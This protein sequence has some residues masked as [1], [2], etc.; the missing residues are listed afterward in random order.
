M[1]DDRMDYMHGQIASLG[2]FV[3]MYI[4]TTHDDANLA[5]QDI[6]HITREARKQIQA[7]A[8]DGARPPIIDGAR[9]SLESVSEITKEF[10]EQR[11]EHEKQHGKTYKTV[12][13]FEPEKSPSRARKLLS[14]VARYTTVK[15]VVDWIK[16]NIIP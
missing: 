16:E 4:T 14:A 3:A 7:S 15:V 9:R 10:L 1:P 11:I 12:I 5:K 13:V 6:E 2:L 8:D